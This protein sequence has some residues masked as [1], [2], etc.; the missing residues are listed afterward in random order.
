[1]I[2]SRA[3]TIEY[4]SLQRSAIGLA[5]VTHNVGFEFVGGS[6]V[7]VAICFFMQ[8]S[9]GTANPLAFGV[10]ASDRL[11]EYLMSCEDICRAIPH[12]QFPTQNPTMQHKNS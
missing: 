11:N 8:T 5:C 7:T 3:G 6:K 4:D 2:N 10:H 1:M 9:Y 12:T